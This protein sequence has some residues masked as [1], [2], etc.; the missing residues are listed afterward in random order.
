MRSA[1]ILSAVLI[2]ALPAAAMAQDLPAPPP[3]M[4]AQGTL[5]DVVAQGRVTRV[6]DLATISVGV[7]T[8]GDTARA[9]MAANAAQMASLRAALKKAGIA[10]RDVQT[11]AISLQAQFR[12]PDNQPPVLIGYQASNRLTVRF[13]DIDRAGPI[14]DALVGA[15]ANRIDGPTLSIE[16]SDAA[17]DEARQDAIRRARARAELYARAA[18]LSVDRIVM[19]SESGLPSPPPSPVMFARMAAADVATS[20]APGEQDVTVT[21]NVR[22]LLR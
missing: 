14:L 13:R 2:A 5:L 18:G 3:A 12:Y 7:E 19:I 22:F 11:A 10:D 21:V 17:L 16:N 6:P 20:I 8:Q 9:A 15:G 4:T 1:L